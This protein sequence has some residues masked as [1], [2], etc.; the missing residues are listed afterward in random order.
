MKGKII[1]RILILFLLF[2]CITAIIT[3]KERNAAVTTGTIGASPAV[4][5]VIDP[6]HGGLD[7]GAVS[8]DGLRESEINLAIAL[9]MNDLLRLFG[10]CPIMTR[11]GEVL[12]YPENAVTIREKKV[13][14]QKRR[15]ALVNSCAAAIL[16]SIHQNQ[17][18]DSRP[19][20][21][22]VFY[23]REDGSEALG[24]LLH[25][26]L[27]SVFCPESRR[28]AAPISDS[29][30]LMKHV[31]CPAALVECGFLS[32][33]TEAKIL[34]DNGYQTA[35]AAVLCASCLQYIG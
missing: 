14:D 1:R 11:T 17:Y 12:E 25:E 6:G 32:N 34:A 9:K 21:V 26:N 16:V 8:A 13:W 28:V 7:G 5:L 31:T 15:V 24:T 30:F 23:G 33:P 35:L 4:T 3:Y 18:P 27:R 2:C 20:G 19:S 22:Q 29:I 10:I